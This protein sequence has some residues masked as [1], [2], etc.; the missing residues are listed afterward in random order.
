MHTENSLY[1]GGDQERIQNAKEAE[2]RSK[3][4]K[5]KDGGINER[6]YSEML[7]KK[8]AYQAWL[9]PGDESLQSWLKNT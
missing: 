2:V 1:L 5:K 3:E 9:I 6:K 7:D 8:Y 4:E